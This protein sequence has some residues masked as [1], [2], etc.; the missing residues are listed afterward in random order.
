[1]LW[2]V[3]GIIYLVIGFL[4]AMPIMKLTFRNGWQ[5]GVIVTLGWLPIGLIIGLVNLWHWF[6]DSGPILDKYPATLS[7]PRSTTIRPGEKP[8]EAFKRLD[9]GIDL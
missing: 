5:I 2:S 8:S 9:E 6:K 7:E 4:I 3:I 1:M